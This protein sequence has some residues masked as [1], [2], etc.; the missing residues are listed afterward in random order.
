MTS[1][2]SILE[3][4]EGSTYLLSSVVCSLRFLGLS[5]IMRY[6]DLIVVGMACAWYV[7]SDQ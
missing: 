5:T 4:V 7:C 2:M 1:F 6:I 3:D